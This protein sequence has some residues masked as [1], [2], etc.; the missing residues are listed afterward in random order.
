MF[1]ALFKSMH[2]FYTYTVPHPL[3]NGAEHLG[4]LPKFRT[5]AQPV[6]GTGIVYRTL[7]TYQNP[8]VY[9]NLQS[10]TSGLGGIQA[11]QLFGA[12]L[13]DSDYNQVE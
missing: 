12:P 9:V 2:D 1:K 11:G 8:Q 4:F 7:R 5:P 13:T 3:T 6:V 10:P